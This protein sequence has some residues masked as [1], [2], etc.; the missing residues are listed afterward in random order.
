M[1]KPWRVKK[2]GLLS[3]PNKPKRKKKKRKKKKGK[4]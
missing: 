1:K 3:W 4:K 2:G